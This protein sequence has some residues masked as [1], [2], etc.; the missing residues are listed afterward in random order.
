MRARYATGLLFETRRLPG[1]SAIAD[2]DVGSNLAWIAL[3]P[4]GGVRYVWP[5]LLF[6][7]SFWQNFHRRWSVAN[8]M[9]WFGVEVVRNPGLGVP[10]AVGALQGQHVI[11][12]Y[13]DGCVGLI[14]I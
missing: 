13:Y 9:R 3:L 14:K 2:C 10:E 11:Y 1:V 6:R 4:K 7:V 12:T 8:G 5:Y